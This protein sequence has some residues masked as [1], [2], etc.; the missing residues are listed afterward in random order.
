[1]KQNLEEKVQNYYYFSFKKSIGIEKYKTS[2]HSIV[3][4]LIIHLNIS[5]CSFSVNY[6]LLDPSE[7]KRLAIHSVPM[8]FPSKV[9]RA[10]VPWEA[11]YKDNRT[12]IKSHLFTI[13]G[14]MI[15]LQDIWLKR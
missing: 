13:S 4:C 7:R 9:I 15:L 6:V 3:K 8:P 1:M 14:I 2:Y 10:P 12:W 11:V 5:F